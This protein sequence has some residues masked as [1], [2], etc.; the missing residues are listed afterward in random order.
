MSKSRELYYGAATQGAI[1]QT[2][3]HL[4]MKHSNILTETLCVIFHR[5]SDG[6]N[7]INFIYIICI[8]TVIP[9]MVFQ[10]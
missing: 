4:V 8:G 10:T 9:K 6:W 3:H 7:R 1:Q 5:F 2:F